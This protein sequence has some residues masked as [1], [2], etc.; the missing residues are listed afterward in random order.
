MEKQAEACDFCLRTDSGH[1]AGC[2]KGLKKRGV[3][4][5]A[6]LSASN[7]WE[8][9]YRR[10]SAGHPFSRGKNK[11]YELGFA[12]GQIKEPSLGAVF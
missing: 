10:A 12:I 7:S 3:A 11:F 5:F 6:I 2:P 8:K 9:G 1:E 4:S